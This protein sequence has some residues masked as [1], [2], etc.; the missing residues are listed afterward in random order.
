MSEF[1]EEKAYYI[2]NSK[3]TSRIASVY[4]SKGKPFYAQ[5]KSDNF[6]QKFNLKYIDKSKGLCII[7]ESITQDSAGLPFVQANAPVL[8]MQ[9]PQEWTFKQTAIGHYSIG[10]FSNK[11]EYVWDLSRQSE[12]DHK[13][14]I[15]PNTHQE[16]QS[17]TFVESNL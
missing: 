13:I 1:P 7:T 2:Q 11:I 3:E 14:V 16:L 9:I 10:M 17:W 12:D 6:F 8:G 5:P 4:V 15:K